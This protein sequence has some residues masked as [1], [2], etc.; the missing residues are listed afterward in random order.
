M[1]DA[2]R[3]PQ[4]GK[5]RDKTF[6]KRSSV[7]ILG[8]GG[9]TTEIAE[10]LATPSYSQYSLLGCLDDDPK[11]QG[12]NFSGVPVLGPLADVHDYPD[13]VLLLALGSPRSY[14]R[15]LPLIEKLG[16]EKRSF[17]TII[18][19]TAWVSPSA[20]IGQGCVVLAYS[21]ISNN[22]ILEDH[23]VLLSHC[24]VN[25]D[26]FIGRGTLSASGVIVSGNVRIGQSCYLGAGSKFRDGV[27]VGD[28]TL[29]GVG[30]VVVSNLPSAGVFVGNPA[31]PLLR[32]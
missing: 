32:S 9:L 16:L 7:V 13:A 30:A 21:Q 24:A 28:G 5:N 12:L 23:V 31:R 11:K 10:L 22:A 20:R 27:S 18:H 2:A 29:I 8:A 4:D 15:R 14:S 26:S 25:H 3:E 6:Q 1:S 19:P 17:L